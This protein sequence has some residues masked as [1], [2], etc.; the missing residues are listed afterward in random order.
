MDIFRHIMHGN[1]LVIQI[2]EEGM[3][4]QIMRSSLNFLG[5]S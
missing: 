3:R 4:D 5:L 1:Y 2:A